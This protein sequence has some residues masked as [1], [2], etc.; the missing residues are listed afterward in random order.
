MSPTMQETNDLFGNV[1]SLLVDAISHIPRLGARFQLQIAKGLV[2]YS[3]A[4]EIDDEFQQIQS[5][6]LD[7]LAK[8]QREMSAYIDQWAPFATIWQ[9]DRVEFMRIFGSGDGTAAVHFAR[10]INQFTDISN[11]IAIR[12][13]ALAVNFMAVNA[14]R[15]RKHISSQIDEWQLEYLK[16]LKKKTDEKIVQL[17]E[18]TTENGRIVA[19]VPQNVDDL[20]RCCAFYENLTRSISHWKVVLVELTDYFEMLQRCKVISDNE[21]SD[22]KANM[23]EQ[24]NEYLDKLTS[25]AEV[26]DDVKNCFKLML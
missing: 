4:I 26:L 2:A 22:M 18:Y 15:L 8:N 16:L 17:F 12:E 25:A 9:F 19:E 1:S 3:E 6:I 23:I 11:Q 20:H 13:T 7:E 21:Y 24:W 10:D 14:S 5:N